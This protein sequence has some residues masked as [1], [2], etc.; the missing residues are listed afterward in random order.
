MRTKPAST[1]GE[2]AAGAYF[3]AIASASG[4]SPEVLLTFRGAP[5][6]ALVATDAAAWTEERGSSSLMPRILWPVGSLETG[7]ISEI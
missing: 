1:I 4:D 3:P 7:D 2:N 5:G 6:R